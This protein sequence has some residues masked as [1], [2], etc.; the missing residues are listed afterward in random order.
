[1]GKE[2]DKKSEAL[3]LSSIGQTYAVNYQFNASGPIKV[4]KSTRLTKLL[5][6]Y[7]DIL[8]EPGRHKKTVIAFV[9]ELDEILLTLK[10]NL[11]KLNAIVSRGSDVQSEGLAWIRSVGEADG[12][13]S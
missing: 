2:P 11:M 9:I 10:S 3:D 4:V 6:L 8:W 1:M 5:E 12:Q 7:G 13:N